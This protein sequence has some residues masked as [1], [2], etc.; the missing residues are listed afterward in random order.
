MEETGH[1]AGGL[2]ASVRRVARSV[3]N[4]V[5]SRLEL[6][7]V[8]LREERIHVANVLMLVAAC[9]VCAGM[10]LLL[11]TMSVLVIFWEQRILVVLLLTGLY[12]GGALVT[13]LA[14]RRRL[15][16]RRPFSATL[17]QF[18]K[19]RECLAKRN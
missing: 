15:R 12:A 4:L 3:T 19:D 16:N 6:F 14:L 9:V 11:V 7:L 18:K 8:E 2:L 1:E 10:A 17:E 13:F 5:H